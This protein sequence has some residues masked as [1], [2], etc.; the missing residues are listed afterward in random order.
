LGTLGAIA[1]SIRPSALVTWQAGLYYKA[2]TGAALGVFIAFQWTLA[3]SRVKGQTRLAKR[4]YNWHQLAGAAAPLLFFAH[5]VSLGAGYLLMLSFVYMVNNAIGL[6]NPTA[7]PRLRNH[8]AT[9]TICHIALS[10]LLA[11]LAIHHGWTA[12]YYE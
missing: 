9:W 2:A 6:L 1:L 8:L 5:S 11:A 7:F 4:L 10:V 12:L 3:L